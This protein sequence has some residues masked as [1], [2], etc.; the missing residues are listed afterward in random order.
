MLTPIWVASCDSQSSRNGRFRRTAIADGCRVPS[1]PRV[2]LRRRGP[3]RDRSVMPP[4]PAEAPRRRSSPGRPGSRSRSRRVSSTR[5][6]S[7]TWR[8]QPWQRRPMSAPRRSTSHSRAPHGWARR[9][10]TTSPRSSSSA[11]R[12]DIGGSVIRGGGP[13]RSGTSFALGRG[14]GH[15]LDGVD[16]QAHVRI[17]RADLGDH[18]RRS[19]SACRSGSAG[20]RWPGSRTSRRAAR[21]RPTGP[22]GAGDDDARHDAHAVDGDGLGAGV[23]QL[24]EQ[25]LD[26]VAADR[27]A[28]RR[29]RSPAPSPRSARPRRGSG[30]GPSLSSSTV[31]APRSC[32]S[33]RCAACCLS[34]VISS[35]SWS[36]PVVRLAMSW[37]SSSP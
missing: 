18:A 2:V 13:H 3:S 20:C 33:I 34:S 15:R 21:S 37:V 14:Q 6:S 23:A 24:V 35:R 19:A 10:R 29:S 1:V 17:G 22:R 30:R 5:R 11:G 8:P 12:A 4:A 25:V 16:G 36:L 9:R 31:V 7:M 32:A 28:A 27:A 26:A